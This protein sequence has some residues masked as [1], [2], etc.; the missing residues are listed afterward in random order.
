VR[1]TL[2]E[3][4]EQSQENARAFLKGTPLRAVNPEALKHVYAS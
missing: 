4:Y 3:F 2:T 1:E